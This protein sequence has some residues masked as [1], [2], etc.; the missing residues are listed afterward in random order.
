MWVKSCFP[1]LWYACQEATPSSGLS[2]KTIFRS[3][4]SRANVNWLLAFRPV[5]QLSSVQSKLPSWSLG[6]FDFPCACQKGSSVKLLIIWS[7]KITW[8]IWSCFYAPSF[9]SQSNT[10]SISLI[11]KPKFFYIIESF[12]KKVKTEFKSSCLTHRDLLPSYLDEFLWW[13]HNGNKISFFVRMC[14]SQFFV[15]DVYICLLFVYL[16]ISTV[17]NSIRTQAIKVD[18]F[19][20][21]FSSNGTGKLNC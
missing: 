17:L 2:W 20:S 5:S 12:R 13:Q 3:R 18:C 7:F 6:S 9:T 16:I 4:N 11:L 1:A 21:L 15:L 19:W 10:R 14:F 8:G